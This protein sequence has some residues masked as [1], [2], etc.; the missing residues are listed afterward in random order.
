M[1][2]VIICA[3]DFAQSAA[4]DDAILDLIQRGVLTAT[5]C[6]TLSPAWA[7]S[8]TQLT[9][10]IR[11][12]ADIGL[13]L[14]FTEFS[15]SLRLSHPLLVIRSL[16]GLLEQQAVRTNI[17]QQL[18]AFEQA[19]GTAPD[20]VDGHL[21]VHQLPVIRDALLAEMQQRYGKL[22]VAERPWL[23]VSSPPAGSGFKARIIHWLGAKALQTNAKE[24]GFRVSPRL[25]GVYDFQGDAA[26]Y[27]A[28]WLTWAS[29]LKQSSAPNEHSLPPVLMC[30]PAKPSDKADDS[31]PIAKARV[32]EWQVM[33]SPDF[34]T[35]LSKADIQPVKGS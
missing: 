18:N 11:A 7:E 10:A 14:D 24:S 20:Y 9:P 12:K 6:M 4:I 23:R 22:P 34:K 26:A 2:S 32:I 25:L 5:S 30:H 35:W 31:D 8:A 17:Q 27:Q 29:Q 3:D 28:H 15:Q 16:L 19:T 13:H 33:Q 1:A 21:H